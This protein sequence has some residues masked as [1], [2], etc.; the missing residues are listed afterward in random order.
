MSNRIP[1]QEDV[2]VA[3]KQSL[4]SRTDEHGTPEETLVDYLCIHETDAHGTKTR[5]LMIAGQ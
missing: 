4:F 5:W 3:I 1:V 2:G